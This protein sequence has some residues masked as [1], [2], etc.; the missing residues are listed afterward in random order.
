MRFI[1]LHGFA[2]GPRSRKAQAFQSAL[3]ARDIEME[4]PDLAMGDFEHLTISGQLRVIEELLDGAPCRLVGSSMGGYLASLYADS[5]PEVERLVLLA[6]AFGFVARWREMQGPEGIGRWWDTGWLDVLHYG[7]RAIRR[8]HYGLL[9][10][11]ANFPGFPDFRQPALIFHGVNDPVVPVDL[12]RE[13]V[14]S[15]ANACLRE[16]DSD[17]ELLDVLDTITAEAVP[18]L[19]V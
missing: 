13:F 11:A 12:S 1:Y 7:D 6:P 3:A 16:M 14:W 2:S 4:I 8:V 17:H 15:H 9:E 19:G 5:H 18:Y 10:D